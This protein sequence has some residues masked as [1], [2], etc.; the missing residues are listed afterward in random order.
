[1]TNRH[2]TISLS[3]LEPINFCGNILG[4]TAEISQFE[5]PFEIE[6]TIGEHDFN[7]C[8]GCQKSLNELISIFKVGIDGDETKKGFPFCCL[9]HA[10]LVNLKEFKRSDFLNAPEMVARKIIYSH[11]H[12]LNNYKSENWYKVITDYIDYVVDSFGHMPTGYGESLFLGN[13]FKYLTS[14]LIQCNDIPPAKKNLIKDYINSYYIPHENQQTDLRILIDTYQSW[15]KVF[16]FELNSYFGN[17]KLQFEKQIPILKG[18]PETNIYSGISRV[19][20]HSKNSLI[21]ALIDL[22]N[23]LLSQI[24]GD[25]LYENGLITDANKIKIELVRNKRKLKISNGYKNS[26]PDET[27]RYRKMIKEWFRDEEQFINEITP[28]L[29]AVQQEETRNFIKPLQYMEFKKSAFFSNLTKENDCTAELAEILYQIIINT[30]N[31]LEQIRDDQLKSK[32]LIKETY[33]DLYNNVTFSK[34]GKLFEQYLLNALS[35][36]DSYVY[37]YN[38]LAQ[39]TNREMHLVAYQVKIVSDS[40]LYKM[41]E[42]EKAHNQKNGTITILPEREQ[43]VKIQEVFAL[44]DYKNKLDLTLDYYSEF[45]NILIAINRNDEKRLIQSILHLKSIQDESIESESILTVQVHFELT[46][47]ELKKFYNY[48]FIKFDEIIRDF[49]LHALAA[50]NITD[51]DFRNKPMHKIWNTYSNATDFLI[52]YSPEHKHF[53]WFLTRALDRRLNEYYRRFRK[54]YS[55]SFT[56]NKASFE[57]ES[58]IDNSE[59]PI[60]KPL[61]GSGSYLTDTN[62]IIENLLLLFEHFDTLDFTVINEKKKEINLDILSYNFYD[63]INI[64]KKQF[65]GLHLSSNQDLLTKVK[66]ELIKK[67]DMLL[68]LDFGIILTLP[69]S[70]KSKV[71]IEPELLNLVNQSKLIYI[72]EMIDYIHSFNNSPTPPPKE[73]KVK[74]DP[75]IP[76]IKPVFKPEAIETIYDILKVYFPSQNEELKQV[77]DTGIVPQQKLIFQGSGKTLLDFFKQ[78]M[79]GQFLTIAVQEDF[80]IW[81]S[82]SFEYLHRRQPNDFSKKY[83]STIISGNGRAAKGNRLIDVENKNGKFEIVQREIRNREQN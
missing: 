46:N 58:T 39:K 30:I 65:M 14:L 35:N 22:T 36:D 19:K 18:K 32:D 41:L 17:L 77:L 4:Y 7:K 15:L 47:E 33:R 5:I 45:S 68:G 69:D 9:P 73:D 10:R 8:T 72:N 34:E 63:D 31:L 53:I 38:Y 79:K 28:L 49:N 54:S 3:N 80:L 21:E 44:K 29:K 20:L 66:V 76:V 78:L 6:P 50:D 26:S 56:E 23:E 48:G 24:S 42:K 16:P 61:N 25:K 64:L 74:T 62:Q 57:P 2:K 51:D 43:P 81:L 83:A 37:A 71:T 75:F 11:Q 59:N 70:E 1:M 82:N 12:I 27:H 55:I 60:L 52:I 13:Y 40:E 67:R